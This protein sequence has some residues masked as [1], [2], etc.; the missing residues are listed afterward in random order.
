MKYIY[1]KTSLLFLSF[2][3]TEGQNFVVHYLKSSNYEPTKILLSIAP[4][5]LSISRSFTR[6]GALAGFAGLV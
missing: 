4:S 1:I 3:L 6:N 2:E 5:T